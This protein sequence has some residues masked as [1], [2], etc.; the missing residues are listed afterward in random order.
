VHCDCMSLIPSI[1]QSTTCVPRSPLTITP[2]SSMTS[3][4]RRLRNI[5]LRRW[6]I[7]AYFF[8]VLIIIIRCRVV[9]Y[10]VDTYL[11]G[12]RVLWNFC[13]QLMLK[14]EFLWPS[15]I[16][17]V[18]NLLIFISFIVV[19]QCHI[20]CWSLLLFGFF[21]HCPHWLTLCIRCCPL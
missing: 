1:E 8:R 4:V 10:C 2:N 3:T 11:R 19:F 21:T 15:C 12:L 14:E 20:Y 9:G 16:I 18:W 7:L 5:L 13:T 6:E 17:F